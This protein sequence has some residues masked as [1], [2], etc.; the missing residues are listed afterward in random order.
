MNIYIS[1]NTPTLFY[2]TLLL[3]YYNK[4]IREQIKGLPEYLYSNQDSIV[5]AIYKEYTNYNIYYYIKTSLFLESYIAAIKEK[6]KLNL[7]DYYHEFSL[8]SAKVLYNGLLTDS[9][10]TKLFLEG[11][12]EDIRKCVYRA[13]KLSLYSTKD[14]KL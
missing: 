10:Y 14:Q 7:R 4:L 6:L 8:L 13:Y 9:Q 5:I 2:F 3:S 12:L 11:L 1:Y